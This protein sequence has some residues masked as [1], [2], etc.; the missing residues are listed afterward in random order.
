MYCLYVTIFLMSFSSVALMTTLPDI[1]GDMKTGLKT[2]PI[3]YGKKITLIIALILVIFSFIIS[4][5][6]NDPIAST[7]AIVSIPFFFFATF[8]GLDK[9]IL[10]SI[11]YPIFLLNFFVLPFY[12]FLSV[13]IIIIYYLSKYYYWYRFGLHYPTFLVDD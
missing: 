11:R 4:M 10:R 3:V 6:N 1:L 12:P 9:D 13:P 8:R 2:F 5:I 7:A